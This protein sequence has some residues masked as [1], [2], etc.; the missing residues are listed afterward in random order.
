[1][2]LIG[3][4]I[5]NTTQKAFLAQ[6]KSA[7]VEKDVESAY[8]GVFQTYYQTTFPS[9]YGSDGY[10]E[11]GQ[12]SLFDADS[13]RLLLEVKFGKNLASS[14]GRAQIVVQALYYLKKFEQDGKPLPN[15]I[16][17]GDENEIFTIYAPKL[18]T[19]LENDYDWTIAPS[20]AYEKNQALYK[21]LIE[22]PNLNVYVF[23]TRSSAFDIND[24]FTS[25]STLGRQDGEFKKLRVTEANLRLVFDEFT[26]MVFGEE[27]W[28]KTAKNIGADESVSIF[29]QSILGNQDTYLVPTKKNTLHLAGGKEI[30]INGANYD[31]FFS[32]YDRKY[33]AAEINIITAIADQLIEEIKRRFHG[34][35]WTPTVWAN[36]AID[37]MSHDLGDD[38]REKYVVWDPAAG[39]KNLT[40]DYRFKRLFTSTIHQ[41]EIDMSRQYNQDAA[42]FQYDFLND[43]IDINPDSDYRDLRMPRELFEALKSNQPIVFYTN[44]PY[45]Q[46]TEQGET[47][48]DGIA[49]T[50]IGKIMRSEGFG[51]ASAELYTQFIY[52]VQKLTRDFGLTNVFFFFFFNKGFLVSPAFEKFTDQMLD[53]FQFN[54]G[55]MLNA[56]EFQGTAS[57]WGIIFSNFAVKQGSEPRQAE[58]TFRVEKSGLHGTEKI[59]EHTIRRV[60]KNDTISAWLGAIKPSREVFNNGAYPRITGGFNTK[61]T[62]KVSG[63]YKAGA[64]GFMHNNGMNVQYSDKYVNLNSAMNFADHGVTVTPENFE[65]VCVTF[66]ARKSILPDASWVND[67]DVFRRPSDSLQASPEW[68]EFVNDSVVYSLFHRASYQ[69]SLRNFVYNGQS[70]NVPNEWFFMSR[71]A[72]IT[73]AEKHDLSDIVFD[74]QSSDDRYV[75]KYLRDQPLSPEANELL[76]AGQKMIEQTFAQRFLA[77]AEHPEWH[78]LA[79]DAGFYQA[80]KIAGLYKNDFADVMADM[81]QA[82]TKL[83]SK[84]RHQVYRDKILEK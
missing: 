40:R 42:S 52:R 70:Y 69:T 22:D 59:S 9:P 49:D 5:P 73:L 32:R 15:V 51:H 84:I 11:R 60:S 47:S 46:A 65:R 68:P 50:L 74:A 21:E 6:L 12:Q 17:G 83:E 7:L 58:F 63:Y 2:K 81:K 39:T 62:D 43:D 35:F 79:W 53:H 30:H 13:L 77:N 67:K 18:Y 54:G 23:D 34:D 38:W 8:K 19:Y 64:I 48:K 36:R 45:G 37:L 72:I 1:M 75:Y 25:I 76:V 66:A 16:V 56:G 26:R 20:S 33:T 55:F 71:E 10:I 57:N 29:I 61:N 82:L 4:R 3:K 80:S 24:V 31:A 44:P 14:A 27:N 41:S 78:L 28:I